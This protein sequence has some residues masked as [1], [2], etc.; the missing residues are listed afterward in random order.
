MM[1]FLNALFLP[2]FS[3]LHSMKECTSAGNMPRDPSRP[4]FYFTPNL[5][6]VGDPGKKFSEIKLGRLMEMDCGSQPFGCAAYAL[7]LRGMARRVVSPSTDSAPE[8]A[9]GGGA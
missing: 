9:E 2:I 1:D 8:L 4:L 5:D 6:R 7:T 3:F